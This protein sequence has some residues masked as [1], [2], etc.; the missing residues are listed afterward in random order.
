MDTKNKTSIDNFNATSHKTDVSGSFYWKTDYYHHDNAFTMQDFIENHLPN[1][2]EVIFD[3][4]S[5]AEVKQN[6]TNTIFS[7]DAKGNGDS[8]NHVVNWHVLR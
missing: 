8:F 6:S 4:G 5:Y 2:F 3:D 7:L 1:G